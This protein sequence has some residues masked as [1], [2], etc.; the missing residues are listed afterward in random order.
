MMRTRFTS[1]AAARNKG[2]ALVRSS[3]SVSASW[4]TARLPLARFFGAPC[5]QAGL[6][7]VLALGLATSGCAT[8]DSAANSVGNAITGG[9][10]QAPGTPGYV[11]G[12][13]GGVSADEPRAALVA[14]E[15]LSGGG[16]AAEAA[17]AAAFMLTVTLPSR[18]G[19]GGGGAC[20]AY[21]P[22]KSSVNGG[23]PEAVLFVPGPGG[24]A[25]GGPG[26]R[27]AAVPMMA[28]GLYALYA[29]YG[30][31]PF[32]LLTIYAEQS[33]R[34][35]IPVSRAFARDLAVVAGPLAGD[36][37]AREVFF[38][39][40]GQ[41]LAEGM[42][43]T[44]PELG[45]TLTQLRVA[46]VGDLHVG[47]LARKIVEASAQVG[48]GLSPASL[49]DSLP[50]YAPALE[51]D[52]PGG[53]QAMFLPPPADGGLAAAAAFRVLMA[54]PGAL[55]AAQQRAI[56]VAAA[57]RA[58]GGQ[59]DPAALLAA[60]VPTASLP[61][62][63]ASTSLV[64]LDRDGRAVACTF[65]MNNLFGTGRIAPGTGV[66][67]AASPAWLPPPLLSAGLAWNPNIH[68]FHAAVAASGQEGAPVA[69]ADALW[70]S[71]QT[72]KRSL[73][74]SEPPGQ[75]TPQMQNTGAPVVLSSGVPMRQVPEPGRANAI[76]CA[77]YLP[78]DAGS[79]A[80]YTD[81]RGAG[82]AVGGN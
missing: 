5:A 55:P 56:S 62:L 11:S 22:D 60:Q 75:N 63:P 40:N 9:G 16:T 68:E 28:R 70:Q 57:W 71:L 45:A 50:S 34:F 39:P 33:A 32:E 66:L 31:R 41:P 73:F 43:M 78:G 42:T 81:P 1:G 46:G 47:V 61:P 14:R 17:V 53:D 13:L 77:G 3:V 52:A 67:L 82:L 7:I 27:P 48:G 23:V 26:A 74:S 25:V 15:V 51:V 30:R 49:R 12:F 24:G 8:L 37:L 38:Q 54:S 58:Q 64:T 2:L 21:D 19:L 69:A 20:L 18:A 72:S 59:G 79:C 65:S 29:R 35:G 44:Q 10:G 6:G 4:M 80:W 76:S 36:P